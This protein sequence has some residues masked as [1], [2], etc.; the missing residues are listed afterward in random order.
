[1]PINDSSCEFGDSGDVSVS[2]TCGECYWLFSGGEFCKKTR[3]YSIGRG[4]AIPSCMLEII[5]FVSTEVVRG[6]DGHYS[7][8]NSA[9][10]KKM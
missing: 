6:G 8:S 5:S 4:L 3:V 10:L 2:E 1:P 7:G 9:L